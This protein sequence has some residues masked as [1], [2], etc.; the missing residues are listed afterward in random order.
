MEL[1][2]SRV[3]SATAATDSPTSDGPTTVEPAAHGDLE[4]RQDREAGRPGDGH[5]P[6]ERACSTSPTPP[7]RERFLGWHHEREGQDGEAADEADDERDRRAGC[8]P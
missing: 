5:R 7:I 4:Q 2:G 1:A 3:A 6:D 8:R